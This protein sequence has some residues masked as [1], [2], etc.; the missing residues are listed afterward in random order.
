MTYGEI[1]GKNGTGVELVPEKKH[2]MIRSTMI[3]TVATVFSK[4]FGYGREMALAAFFGASGATDTYNMAFILPGVL[5]AVI[6]T[7][8]ATTA[9]PVFSEYL[10][11]PRKKQQFWPLVM[12]LFHVLLVI[13]LGLLVLGELFTPQ[14]MHLMAPGF[15][16]EQLAQTIVLARWMLPGILFTLASTFFTA[17]LQSYERFTAPALIGFPYDSILIVAIIMSGSRFGI[18][19]VAV[20]TV[21]G[22]ASQALIQIPALIRVGFRYRPYC[23][24]HH[25]GLRQIFLLVLPVLIGV[26]ANELNILVDKAMA[27]GLAEGSIASLGFAQRA[28]GLPYGLFVLPLITVLFPA[29]SGASAKTDSRKYAALVEKGLTMLSFITIPACLGML[30]LRQDFIRLLY[31]RGQFDASATAL[32]AFAFLFYGLGL[33]ILAWR[34]YLNRAF[35][36]RKDTR[37]PTIAGVIQVMAN[38]IGNLILVRYL[39]HGGLALATTLSAAVCTGLL[40]WRLQRTVHE[41][42]YR[43]TAME[44]VKQVVSGLA[45]AVAVTWLGLHLPGFAPEGAGSLVAFAAGAIRLGVQVVAGAAVYALCATILRST[46]IRDMWGIMG[47]IVAKLRGRI[48]RAA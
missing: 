29:M 43:R 42:S 20:G 44:V 22:I 39:A 26:G 17:I 32:T 46:A 8:L 30:V 21:I 2:S 41:I 33:P 19:G 10:H 36:A 25:P 24:I 31:E 35:Y 16:G 48:A 15:K 28:M 47:D 3:I 14:L 5:F 12:S 18:I 1:W 23:N 7:A 38:I 9:I 4:I 6:G 40:L 27:S 34:D 11:D 37:F 13:V 45:M